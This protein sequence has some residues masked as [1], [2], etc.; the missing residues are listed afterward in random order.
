MRPLIS[1]LAL[2]LCGCAGTKE[3]PPI[4][5]IETVE[6]IREVPVPCPAIRPQRPAPAAIQSDDLETI[7][8]LLAAKLIEFVGPGGYVD[9]SEAIFDLCLEKPK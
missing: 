1:A 2:I 3:A 6:V 4:V 7:A 8:P 5:R 9:Q